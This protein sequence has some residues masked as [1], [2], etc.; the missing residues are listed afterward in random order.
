MSPRAAKLS[1]V[2][3]PL[4]ICGLSLKKVLKLIH[5]CQESLEKTRSK[6]ENVTFSQSAVAAAYAP[7]TV[8]ELLSGTGVFGW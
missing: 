5:A 4:S 7:E 8:T 3:T 1:P 2:V 6:E